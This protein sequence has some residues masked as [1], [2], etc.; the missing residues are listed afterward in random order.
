MFRG[1]DQTLFISK[2][3]FNEIGGFNSEYCIMEDYEFI[4][5]AKK[6]YLF[7]V[8]QADAVVSDRKYKENSYLRVNFANLLVFSLFRWGASQES[9]LKA[10]RKL[11][12]HPKVISLKKLNEV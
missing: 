3:D 6:N 12:N 1:G 2:Y 11:L 9:M 4:I 7:K 8:I 10:Y 5:K